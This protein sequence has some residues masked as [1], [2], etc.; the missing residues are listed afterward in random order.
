MKAP[1]PYYFHSWWAGQEVAILASGPSLE[2]TDLSPLRAVRVA[3]INTSYYYYDKA[4][5]VFTG[6]Y[7]FFERH[8]YNWGGPLII[9]DKRAWQKDLVPCK[10]ATFVAPGRHDGLEPRRDHVSGRWS[11]VN[12]CISLMAHCGVSKIILVGLDLSPG[13]GRQRRAG[14]DEIDTPDAEE[15][16]GRMLGN[17]KTMI[18]PLAERKIKVINAT[19]VNKTPWWPSMTLREAIDYGRD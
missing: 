14:H 12:Q 10:H 6:G 9:A 8:P 3:A 15:R 1:K 5:F 7:Q 16:Y 11:S 19:P 2:V 17:L 13:D 18:K 4:D